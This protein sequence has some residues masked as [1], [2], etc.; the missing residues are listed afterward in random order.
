MEA[1]AE[2]GGGEGWAAVPLGGGQRGGQS[3]ASQAEV[4]PTYPLPGPTLT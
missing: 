4:L 3:Q 2:G 1:V